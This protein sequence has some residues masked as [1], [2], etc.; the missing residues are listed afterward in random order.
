[1]RNLHEHGSSRPGGPAHANHCAPPVPVWGTFV[2]FI[3]SAHGHPY[4]PPRSSGLV[5]PHQQ[6]RAG[7]VAACKPAWP[8]G[9]CCCT[10]RVFQ[11]L[12]KNWSVTLFGF[13]G[14]SIP[15]A[16]TAQ[17]SESQS[18]TGPAASFSCV[19]GRGGGTSLH[20][21]HKG[22]HGGGTLTAGRTHTHGHTVS[23]THSSRDAHK[24]SSVPR[25]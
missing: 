18:L 24:H 10:S 6:Q 12:E 17:P 4:S 16:D 2:N 8:D 21:S 22:A 14:C 23:H 5:C 13:L 11:T 20:V 19:L 3:L 7:S 25:A 15:M 9:H 1:M